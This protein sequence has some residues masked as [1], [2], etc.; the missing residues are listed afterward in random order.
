VFLSPTVDEILFWISS[1]V[2]ESVILLF[3]YLGTAVEERMITYRV[4]V[5]ISIDFR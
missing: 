3:G 1:T 5:Y 4:H 2:Y